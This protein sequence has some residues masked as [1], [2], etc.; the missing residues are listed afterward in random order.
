MKPET[1]SPIPRL[2]RVALLA[3]AVGCVSLPPAPPGEVEAPGAY[4]LPFRAG[5]RHLCI[6]GGPGPFGHT[7]GQRY[8]LDFKMPVGTPVHAAR[9][10]L[11]VAVKQDSAIGGPWRKHRGHGNYVRIRHDDGTSAVYL[12]LK[13]AAV[14]VEKDQSVR[15]GELIAYSGNTGRSAAAHLHFHV[16]QRDADTGRQT[17]LPVTFADVAGDGVPR[18]LWT[19]ESGNEPPDPQDISAP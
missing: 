2:L 10:G 5:T 3:I 15:R 6:Q 8:A 16:V 7:A 12:H 9:G 14:A 19:Y 17:S 4:K 13:Q 1:T 11:V 18:P